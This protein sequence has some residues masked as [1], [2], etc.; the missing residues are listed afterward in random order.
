M[1]ISLLQQAATVGDVVVPQDIVVIVGVLV[2][3]TL[4]IL[5]AFFSSSEIAMFSLAHHRV[6]MLAEEG[7]P[8]GETAA[9]LKENPHRLLVTILVGNNLVNI[10]MSSIATGLLGF[11]LS[12]GKAVLAATFGIT[13]LVLLF[14]ESAPKSYA[15]ENSE[16]WALRIAPWLALSE[17]VLYPLV[18]TFDYLT[19]IVNQLTGGRA[20]IESSYVT[21]SEIQDMI[22]TGEREGVIEEDEREMLQR[23][24]RFNNTIAKEVMTPRLDMTAVPSDAE[25]ETAIQT[26]TQSGHERVPVYENDLD[27]VIG[28]VKLRDLVR[29]HRYGESD[30]VTLDDLIEPTLHVPEGKN[31]DDLLQEMQEER[32]Q[33]VIVIDEFG[34]TEGLITTEDLIEEI[35]GEI[36][37]GEEERPV[38]R[39]DE[40][41]IIVRGEVN[42]DEVNEALDIEL[43]EGEEFETI[44][45]F[46]FN[47]AGRLVEEGEVFI[48]ENVELRVEQ[49]ENTRIRK[50]RIIRHEPGEVP[51]AE[52]D[53]AVE[54]LE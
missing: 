3:A 54:N 43:P 6:Q 33:L 53:P 29:E 28:V 41:T 4:M 44:A 40:G 18:V 17:K 36:L 26:C 22:E 30:G 31:V 27:N 48:Y 11:Y 51:G 38:N 25:V 9:Q 7:L 19:R 45:G 34:T 15:V 14:G 35:V 39:V 37:E 49:V 23:I 42:I 12:Q 16:S 10:A 1:G 47:R 32:V 21:R 46:I 50:A 20:S 52:G 5:S 24:F 8:G 13:T 2:L